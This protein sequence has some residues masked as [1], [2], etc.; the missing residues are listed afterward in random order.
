MSDR[1]TTL[2][3]NIK[4]ARH[5]AMDILRPSARE[6]ETGL[7]FHEEALVVESYSLGISAP[8]SWGRLRRIQE[9]GGSAIELRDAIE[10][11]LTL[12]H[13][14]DETTRELYRQAWRASG[15]NCSFQGAGEESN[16]P[17]RLL[18]RLGRYTHLMDALPGVLARVTTAEDI[19]TH[20]Q[21]GCRTLC[22][23]TNG[24]P[25][26]S[27][28]V[29]VPEELG[30]IRTF[31]QLGVKSM[32]LTYNRRNAIGDGCGEIADG[33]LSAFGHD[34]I[35]EMNSLGI[36]VDLAHT[37]WKT[38]LEAVRASQCPVMISHAACWSV[39]QHIR[40]KSDE[41]IRAVA[42]AG[43]LIGI[44]NVPAFLGGSGDI[45]RL[46][47]HIDYAV[48]QFGVDAVA[49]GTDRSYALPA[50]ESPDD[51]FHLRQRL[52]WES[53]WSGTSPNLDAAWNQPRQVQSLVW[54]N[55][56][57]FT[58]GLVQRG[59]REEDIRKIIGG[60]V[61]RVARDNWKTP[62]TLE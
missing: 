29:S 56:P 4:D 16:D 42:E 41:V 7:A 24:I 60:N 13:L 15:V 26:P 49:I 1:L 37:G 48:N 34:V 44:T 43:G 57:L 5:V 39:H 8:Q 22:L 53:L 2:G 52:P 62:A 17:V 18:R 45:S 3:T 6:L 11:Q 36:I 14:P 46:L 30:L 9:A 21:N 38:S 27:T 12:G 40:C 55:W 61:L 10:E 51:S 59:Y 19:V 58:V 28:R 47:D 54:T 20:H 32:H 31:A 25:L 23:V 35:A 33:G 50:S